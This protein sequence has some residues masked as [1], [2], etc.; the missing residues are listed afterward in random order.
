[1]NRILNAYFVGFSG[2]IRDGAD[3]AQIDAVMQRF[4]WPMGPAHL[5]DVIGMD[6]S[7]HVFELIAGAYPQRMSLDFVN[8][9]RLMADRGRYGQKSG[10][11]FYR[12]ERAPGQRPA[13]KTDAAAWEILAA[14]QREK[15][16]DLTEEE[17]VDRMMLPMIVEAATCL[18]EGIARSAGE[19]DMA[20]ILGLGFPRDRGG[21]LAYADAI[22]FDSLRVRCDRYASLGA[23]YQ[24]ND[25][26]MERFARNGFYD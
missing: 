5:Q 14:I 13:R 2:L 23:A 25:R 10:I 6:T 19:I 16:R 1:V 11:G 9:M 24:L 17:I 20:L 12:Y 26:I 3:F 8:P 7:S 18:V 15:R 22:G 21:A 4:G